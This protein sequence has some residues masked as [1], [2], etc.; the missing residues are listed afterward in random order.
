MKLTQ[1]TSAILMTGAVSLPLSV[2]AQELEISIKNL[3]HGIT[4]TP[5]LIAAHDNNTHLF[6]VGTQADMALQKMAEGGDISELDTM[7]MA[8]DGLSITNPAEGLL[9]PGA[10][11]SQIMFDTQD[12]S[13]LSITAMMLP[14]NDAFIGL[15]SWAI[16]STAGTYTFTLNAYDA[17]TEINDEI[18]NGGGALGTPGIP[19]APQGDAGS[20]ATGVMDMSSNDSVHIHPGIL[21]D[22]DLDGG[23]SDLDSRVH[24]WLNPVAQVTVIVK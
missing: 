7:V 6:E 8:N 17:G 10:E 13:H 5:L 21:G 11:I 4:F 24:R 15:D 3:T 22:T 20:N 19:A 18:I 16:P 1:I 9:A 12:Q 14:T 2:N 23:M